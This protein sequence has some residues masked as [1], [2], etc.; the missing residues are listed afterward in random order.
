MM[1][2]LEVDGV[3]VRGRRPESVLRAF[4]SFERLIEANVRTLK[5]V[6]IGLALNDLLMLSGLRCLENLTLNFDCA[7]HLNQLIIRNKNRG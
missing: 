1:Q 7:Y 2:E 5:S 3:A 4:H 6:N